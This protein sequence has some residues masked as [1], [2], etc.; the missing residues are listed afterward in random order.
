[1]KSAPTLRGWHTKQA[2]RLCRATEPLLILATA[3]PPTMFEGPRSKGGNRTLMLT[4]TSGGSENAAVPSPSDG[5]ENVVGMLAATAGMR[6]C[7]HKGG[8][9]G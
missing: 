7:T 4:N 9:G 1:M 2:A 8:G 5:V 3:H 6:A